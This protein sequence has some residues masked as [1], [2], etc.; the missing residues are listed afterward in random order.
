MKMTITSL[1]LTLLTGCVSFQS[2]VN[3][4]AIPPF[5]RVLVVS[6]LTTVPRNLDQFITQFP[7]QYEVCVADAGTLALAPP[8]SIIQKQAR[9]CRS[10]VVLTYRLNRNYTVG[11][12]ESIQ[13]VNEY[14]VEMTDL[15]TRETFWKA[16]TNGKGLNPTNLIQRL[17][18]DGV[19]SGTVRR[20]YVSR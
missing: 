10:E 6:Q 9:V 12:G 7:D 4:A 17:R 5:T 19:I 13:S 3:R 18:T 11:S 15:A 14:L 20:P 1:L 2:N 16:I 8:D